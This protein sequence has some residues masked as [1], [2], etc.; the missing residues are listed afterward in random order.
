MAQLIA[1]CD[2]YFWKVLRRDLGL[3]QENTERAMIQAV[4][5]I[6]TARAN[7]RSD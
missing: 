5:A 6:G 3:S 1:V 2:L 4:I 7:A